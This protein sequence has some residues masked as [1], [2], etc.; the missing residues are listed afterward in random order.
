MEATTLILS[1]PGAGQNTKMASPIAQLPTRPL[2]DAVQ[3]TLRTKHERWAALALHL[4]RLPGPAPR[5]HHVR[6]ARAVIDDAA[7][8]REGQVFTLATGDIVLLFPAA[9]GGVGLATTLARLFAPDAPDA[10]RLL[11]RWLLPADMPAMF[12]FLEQLPDGPLAGIAAAGSDLPGPD[13]GLAA[14]ASIS[15]A[16]QPGR[17]TDLMERQTGVLVALAGLTRVVPLFRELRFALPLLEAR[18][19]AAGHVTAAPFLFRNLADRMATPMLEAVVDDLRRA[20]PLLAGARRGRPMLH[21]DLGVEAVLSPLFGMVV[22]AARNAGSR[23]AVEIPLLEACADADAFVRAR[24]RIH[25]AGAGLVLD[26]V[27]HHAMLLT[28]PAILQPELLKLDWSPQV[29]LAGDALDAAIAA[30][31]P[32]RIVLHRADAEDAIRWGIARG[33]RRFQGR[34]VD[35][36][37]AA[38]R[39]PACPEAAPCTLRKCAERETAA[40]AAGRAGCGN[41]ELLDAAMPLPNRAAA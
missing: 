32:A 37:L 26:D 3:R 39:L 40:T 6:I 1:A 20:A 9:D 12:A 8:R 28:K 16:V 34:H 10:D 19:A 36:I 17:I 11:S 15:R 31:G 5:P 23:V 35:S 4:S 14:V 7:S 41:L 18:A 33:I 27:S 13:A 21:L 25:A 24:E 38:G 2:R 22:D 30:F 29:P